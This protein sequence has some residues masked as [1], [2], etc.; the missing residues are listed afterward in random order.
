MDLLPGPG[1][2]EC[3]GERTWTRAQ[4]CGTSATMG[5]L[6][7]TDIKSPIE[8][9]NRFPGPRECCRATW[10][11]S[12]VSLVRAGVVNWREIERVIH[13]RAWRSAQ[14]VP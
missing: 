13:I 3:L 5:G 12:D 4:Y 8:I 7:K 1:N 14:T 2:M 11:T 6:P 9:Y 10:L